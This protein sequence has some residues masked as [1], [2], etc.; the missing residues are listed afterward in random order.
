MPWSTWKRFVQEKKWA[1]QKLPTYG[2]A[3]LLLTSLKAC[4]WSGHI[5]GANASPRCL[6][7]KRWLCHLPLF[8]AVS[9]ILSMWQSRCY[10]M[11]HSWLKKISD[12]LEPARM[13]IWGAFAQNKQAVWCKICEFCLETRKK[14]RLFR[15]LGPSLPFTNGPALWRLYSRTWCWTT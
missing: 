15:S 11:R 7:R 13:R 4:D 10:C 6:T 1:K 2:N 3:W 5:F 9:M 14:S 8:K 12:M